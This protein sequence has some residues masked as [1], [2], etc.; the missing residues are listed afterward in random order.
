MANGIDVYVAYQNVRDWGAVKRAGYDFCYV[1]AG[2]GTSTR[3]TNGYGPLGR[4]AGVAM[5]AYWYAQPGNAVQQANMLCDRALG[6]GLADLA[7]ALD[8]ESPFVPGPAAAAFAVA[9]CR[10]VAARGFRPALYANDSMMSAVLPAVRAAVPNVIVWVAR[11]GRNPVN[12]YDVWQWNDKGSVP[13]VSASSVDLNQGL[14]PYNLAAPPPAHSAAPATS[15][16]EVL[17]DGIVNLKPGQNRH[18]PIP[19]AGRPPYL[20]ICGG[21]GDFVDVHQIDFIGQTPAGRDGGNYLGQGWNQGN[22]Q[23]WRWQA[24]RPGY[25]PVPP[26]TVYVSLRYSTTSDSIEAFVS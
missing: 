15:T 10:Q 26:G 25:I 11:Y 24:D 12:G 14:I 23:P 20:Y 4:S 22:G 3:A 8:I 6:E 1:K 19:A 18:A 13:G 5:G 9:F 21:Y 16:I 2:D 7:P 17:E